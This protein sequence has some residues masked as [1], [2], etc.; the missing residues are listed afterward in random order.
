MIHFKGDEGVFYDVSDV[1]INLD[2]PII[3]TVCGIQWR[4]HHNEIWESNKK[5][6]S[7]L[8][9]TTPDLRFDT[10]AE[11]FPFALDEIRY[12]P[13][14]KAMDCTII[15]HSVS[16]NR[17]GSEFIL[18]VIDEITHERPD[19]FMNIQQD[20]PYAMTME[21]KRLNHI[22]IDQIFDYNIYGNSA[23]EGMALGSAVLVQTAHD[24]YGLVNVTKETLKQRILELINN[25]ELLQQ[26]Q[27][28][29]YER[30]IGYHSYKSV[31]ARLER[32]YDEVL[33]N[34]RK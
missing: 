24:L 13:I 1:H 29:A 32:I 14:D 15:G 10:N 33:S 34:D 21:L 26:K 27:R 31:A 28:E 16:T 23:V 4:A 7:K 19:V 18:Q 3:W 20:C 30:F 2:K 11:V 25:R 17:K 22:F 9:C 5:Y 12:K 8:L 6:I